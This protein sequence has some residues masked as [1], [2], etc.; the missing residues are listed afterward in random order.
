MNSFACM[1]PQVVLSPA[2]AGKITRQQ[3]Y[4]LLSEAQWEYAYRGGSKLSKLFS[5]GN[6]GED[7]AENGN[8]KVAA[9]AR[10]VNNNFG[11]PISGDDS[12][13]FTS[14]VGKFQANGFGLFDMHGNLWEWCE[15]V[16]DSKVYGSRNGVTNDPLVSSEGS[17]RV[18]RGGGWDFAPVNCR[19]AFRHWDSPVNRNLDLGFRVSLSLVQ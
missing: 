2:H 15:D 12:Y 9:F 17:I 7:F 11:T 14:P 8:V 18:N 10:K 5:F 19:S 16:N 6:D 1:S 4:R 13:V 3:E